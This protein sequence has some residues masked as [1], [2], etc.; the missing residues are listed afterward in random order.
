M[1][2]IVIMIMGIVTST[3]L[4][5]FILLFKPFTVSIKLIITL[6]MC[7]LIIPHT[8][9][10]TDALVRLMHSSINPPPHNPM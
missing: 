2:M 7:T 9:T 1:I 8:P 5:L 4:V 10:R 3:F 6:I